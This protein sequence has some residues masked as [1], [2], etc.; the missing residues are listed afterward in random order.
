MNKLKRLNETF[1]HAFIG[2]LFQDKVTTEMAA[3]ALIVMSTVQQTLKIEESNPVTLKLKLE[4]AL[5]PHSLSLVEFVYEHFEP[6]FEE[7]FAA[8]QLTV[9]VC[10]N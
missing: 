1:V 9:N 3:E 10:K 2:F 8:H 6:G 4:R 7:A 5:Q